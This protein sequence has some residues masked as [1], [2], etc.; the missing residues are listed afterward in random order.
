MAH[1]D[2][3]NLAIAGAILP[4]IEDLSQTV[5]QNFTPTGKAP[6]EKSV[7]VHNEKVNEKSHSKPSI[8]PYITYGGIT[9]KTL[10]CLHV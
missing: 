6:A 9:N 1:V 10:A 2:A 8:P 4:K 7:T 3:H 5:M